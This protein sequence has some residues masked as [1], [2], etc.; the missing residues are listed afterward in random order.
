M[1]RPVFGALLLAGCAARNPG[2]HPHDMSAAEHDATAAT[3]DAEADAAAANYDPTATETHR[4]CGGGK[5]SHPCWTVVTNPTDAWLAEAAEH[6]KMAAEHRAASEALR[7]AEDAACAGLDEDER[8]ISPFQW[9]AA[10]IAGVEPFNVHRGGKQ[11]DEHLVGAVVT[12]RAVEGL[13]TEWLQR[14]TECH[15]ARNAAVGHDMPEMPDCPLVPKGASVTV[16]S[17]GTGFALAIRSEDDVA[18]ADILAR[19]RRLTPSP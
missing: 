10:D 8:A 7:A 19:A 11:P 4:R 12:V 18:A 1:P 13:T 5:G 9:A 15:L 6:R 2:A 3:L 16:T 17:T 14:V